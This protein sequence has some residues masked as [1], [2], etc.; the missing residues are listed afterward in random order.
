MIRVPVPVR[1]M[2][3]GDQSN[4]VQIT[5]SS[6]IKFGRGGSAKFARVAMNHEAVISGRAI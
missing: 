6:A 5:M 2:V 4:I 3:H 1:M